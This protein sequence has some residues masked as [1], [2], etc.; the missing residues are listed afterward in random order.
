MKIYLV[1]N[2]FIIK[3]ISP[4]LFHSPPILYGFILAK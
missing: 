2:D 3:K 4:F 1:E